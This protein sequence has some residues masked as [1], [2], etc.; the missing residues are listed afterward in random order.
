MGGYGSGRWGDGKADRKALVENCLALD[1]NA[2]AR[3]G[4]GS[5]G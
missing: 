1:I 3:A 4:V 2:L 5:L